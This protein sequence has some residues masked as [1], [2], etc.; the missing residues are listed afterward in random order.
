MSARPAFAAGT[1]RAHVGG[2]VRVGVHLDS[3]L[4]RTMLVPALAIW[5]ADRF[6]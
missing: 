1:R 3:L 5:F 4:M 2:L 6:W